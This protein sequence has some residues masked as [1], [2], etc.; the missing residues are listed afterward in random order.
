MGARFW[1]YLWGKQA[2]RLACRLKLRESVTSGVIAVEQI[3]VDDA[4][5]GLA[6]LLD[7]AAQGETILITRN[8]KPM[9][10]LTPPPQGRSRTVDQAVQDLLVF[11]KGR[12]LG[13]SVKDAIEEG[14]RN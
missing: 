11:G 14:R 4:K 13:M 9:A 6:E 3:D 10:C 12:N 8:G 1:L 7:K 2:F 5:A